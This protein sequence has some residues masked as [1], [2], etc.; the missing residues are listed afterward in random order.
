MPAWQRLDCPFF[1]PHGAS[2]AGFARP[3]ASQQDAAASE[4]AW[5]DLGSTFALAFHTGL[6]ELALIRAA[7]DDT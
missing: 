3:I 2:H 7:G 1:R 6:F 5:R 4:P